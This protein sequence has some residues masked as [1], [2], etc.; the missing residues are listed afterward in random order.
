MEQRPPFRHPVGRGVAEKVEGQVDGGL[1]FAYIV[2]Q[3][4]VN[5]FIFQVQLRGQTKNYYAGFPMV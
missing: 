1:L 2:L 3:V 5:G 4:G